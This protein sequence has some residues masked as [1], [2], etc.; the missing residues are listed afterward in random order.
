M[1]GSLH[2]DPIHKLKIWDP[3]V[4]LELIIIALAYHNRGRRAPNLTNQTDY[5]KKK[6]IKIIYTI[7]TNKSLKLAKVHLTIIT[8]K[9]E[10]IYIYSSIYTIKLIRYTNLEMQ[11]LF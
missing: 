6:E 2:G 4:K 3:H 11:D 10:V 7:I 9:L 5:Y 8:N 1:K